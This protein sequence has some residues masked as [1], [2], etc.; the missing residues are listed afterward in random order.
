MKYLNL[1]KKFVAESFSATDNPKELAHF[2]RAVYWLLQLKPDADEAIQ[3]AA[4]AHDIERAFRDKSS[5]LFD[6]KSYTDPYFTVEHPAK[7][8]KIIADFLAK[9]QAPQDFFSKVKMLIEKHELG[10]DY[11]QNLIKDA[12]SISFFE[13]QIP[14]FIK[15]AQD[16][17]QNQNKI[18]EKFQWMFD[19][20]T[21]ERAKEIAKPFYEEAMTKLSKA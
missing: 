13:N 10:G 4:Y 5:D 14:H 7:G 2:E 3:T 18:K 6:Q 17:P 8:A 19:R 11:D 15:R 16:K 9:N 1:V 20:I 12:D 21:S